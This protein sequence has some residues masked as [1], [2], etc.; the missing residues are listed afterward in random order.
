[1]RQ[2][3]NTG[4]AKQKK[5]AEEILRHKAFNGEK[6][7]TTDDERENLSGRHKENAMIIKKKKC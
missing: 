3:G 5:S 2:K 4:N 7:F 1:M 6:T